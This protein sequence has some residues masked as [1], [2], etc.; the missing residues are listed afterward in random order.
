ML[1][2]ATGINVG[3]PFSWVL[4]KPNPLKKLF[5]VIAVPDDSLTI[6]GWIILQEFQRRRRRCFHRR[7][8]K[9]KNMGADDHT[10]VFSI[11]WSSPILLILVLR[12]FLQK[13][14]PEVYFYPLLVFCNN[15]DEFH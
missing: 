14:Q 6:L 5:H 11:S 12:L 1:E 2:A 13:L 3:A 9:N 4:C 8:T 15:Q 7:N 10:F